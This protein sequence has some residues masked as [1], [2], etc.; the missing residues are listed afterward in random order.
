[1]ASRA[2]IKVVPRQHI[3]SKIKKVNVEADFTAPRGG[4]RPNDIHILIRHLSAFNGDWQKVTDTTYF[5]GNMP[6]PFRAQFD[7]PEEEGTYDIRVI[8]TLDGEPMKDG[9]RTGQFFVD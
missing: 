4:P 3:P 2:T 1:M 8:F 9:E 6:L 5:M 7:K